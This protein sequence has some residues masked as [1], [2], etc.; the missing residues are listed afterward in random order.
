MMVFQAARPGTCCLVGGR[1]LVFCSHL[2]RAPHYVRLPLFI[3]TIFMVFTRLILRFGR[4]EEIFYKT[5][6]VV[7][8]TSSK[9]SG[10]YLQYLEIVVHSKV[11]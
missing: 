10:V 4:N 6:L 5:R 8:K 1:L 11:I 3:C 7:G 9:I 2:A